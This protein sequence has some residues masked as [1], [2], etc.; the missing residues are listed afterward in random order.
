MT[1]VQTKVMCVFVSVVVMRW[2]RWVAWRVVVGECMCWGR[3][4]D[5]DEVVDG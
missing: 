3:L 5:G 1:W 2:W 4:C